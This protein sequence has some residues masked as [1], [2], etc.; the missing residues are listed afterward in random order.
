MQYRLPQQVFPENPNLYSNSDD[1]PNTG[2]REGAIPHAEVNDTIRANPKTIIFGQQT[3]LR[4]GQLMPDEKLPR[5]YA[6]HDMV[7]FFYSAIR[8][9][10]PY[11][12]DALLDNNVS[13]TL[14]QGPSLLVFHHTREHQSFHVG[15]T[16]RTLYIPEMVL[17]EAFEKGYDYW[18]ISEIIIQE[19]WPLLNYL[20]I[21]ETVR[22]LQD[23]LKTRYTIGYY[24]IKD[25]LRRLNK[26]LDDNDD[27]KEDEI[28]VFFRYYANALY[29]LRPSIRERDPYDITDEIF[30]ESRE[31]FW[32]HLKLYD[33]CEIY[34]YPTYFAI[35]RD[36][37]HTA[38]FRLAEELSLPLEPQTTADIMHDLWDEARFKLS[39][40][41]RTEDLLEKLILIGADGMRDF[42]S[43]VAEE[44][45]YGYSY[46]TANRYDGYNIV[47][48]FGKMLQSYSTTFT[49]KMPGSL[50]HHF[51]GLH[52]YF[53]QQKRYELFEQFAVMGERAQEENMREVQEMLYRMIEVRLRPS[54]AP[55]F[56]R[57]VELAGSARVLIDAG[58]GLVEKPEPNEENEHLCGLLAM[59]D[60]HP[61]YHTRFLDQY[62]ELSGQEDVVI[63]KHLAPVVER[64]AEYL[65]ENARAYSSDPSGFSTRHHHFIELREY[66]PDSPELLALLAALFIRLDAS[67]N[68]PELLDQ[69]RAL[70]EYAR[71]ALDEI[72]QNPELF[73]DQQRGAIGDACRKILKGL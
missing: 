51:N 35:D 73:G 67:E 64:L 37:A 68:Y 26:H 4:N 52:Q 11:L 42:L 21:L 53:L 10:P 60:R 59:L 5:F 44:Q 69:V 57:R 63:K 58:Q 70:G 61:M 72:A 46:V 45:V 34:Q 43:T 28:R 41:L 6:G 3:R 47:D 48:G 14:V 49:S 7:K 32:S 20:L 39:R 1:R 55:D 66:D 18:A 8:Q 19:A 54:Q 27:K 25:T 62:R 71:P 13:V 65:P 31:H 40:S 33:L 30:D 56:K 15:R 24:I 17:R 12:I 50:G 22:R 38:A 2:L 23:H 16:R 9:L 36:I 29:R